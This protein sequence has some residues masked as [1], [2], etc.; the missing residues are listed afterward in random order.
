MALASKAEK[1]PDNIQEIRDIL[2]RAFPL[3]VDPKGLGAGYA[4]PMPG[5]GAGP[6]R[7][8][9]GTYSGDIKFPSDRRGRTGSAAFGLYA[10]DVGLAVNKNLS[11]QERAFLDTFATGE[12]PS[13]SYSNVDHDPGGLGGRYQFLKSTW[14]NWAR[15]A[16]LDPGQFSP[17][18][19]DKVA[20]LYASPLVKDKTGK[21]LNTLLSSGPAGVRQAIAAISPGAWNAI[22]N[23]D[24]DKRGHSG[25]VALFMDK[26]KKEQ[27][28]DS[29]ARAAEKTK[30]AIKKA[31]G[32]APAGHLHIPNV[33]H[34]GQSSEYPSPTEKS[35]PQSMN[36]MDLFQQER[37]V[38][39]RVANTAGASVTVQSVML[40]A[41]KGSFA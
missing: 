32:G 22:T 36:N 13:G 26:L 7:T 24:R 38:H 23:I 35:G 25:A 29:A 19:Q 10:S 15:R 2:N 8:A 18:N 4:N 40:G 34:G 37:G 9:G 6:G 39:V 20:L 16:G 30:D 31:D 41:V 14:V 28:A 21:D 33:Y 12:T 17:E 1:V 11:A 5:A 3:S 27:A